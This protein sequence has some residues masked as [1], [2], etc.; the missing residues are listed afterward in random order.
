MAV[1]LQ[2]KTAVVTGGSRGIGRGIA[3]ELAARGANVV[4]DYHANRQAADEVSSRIHE[5]GQ[6]CVAVQ[7]DVGDPAQADALVDAGIRVTGSL[8]ILVSNAG[9]TRDALLVRMTDE[10]WSEVLRTNLTGAFNVTRAAGRQMM[11]QRS[12]RIVLISSV[13]AFAGNVGQANYAASKAGTIA[14]ARTAA[15][16]LGPRGVTVNVIAPGFVETDMTMSLDSDVISA[17]LASIP[18]HRSGTPDDVARAVAFLVSDEASYIT[19]Q[20]LAVDGGMSC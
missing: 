5:L 1:T 7:A 11:R 18:L 16:E 4:I 9:I 6:T 8:D 17:Y 3:L 19:G 15:K 13:V 10:K 2:G 14:L 20:V 12:G